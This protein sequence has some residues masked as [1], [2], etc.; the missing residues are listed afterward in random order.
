MAVSWRLALAACAALLSAS[1]AAAVEQPATKL[2]SAPLVTP[3]AAWTYYGAGTTHTEGLAAWKENG[4]PVN[5]PEIR[6]QA[7]SLGAERLAASQITAAEYAQAVFDYVYNN[8]GVEHRFG[9]GKGGRGALIEKYGTAFDQAELM[10]KLLREGGV[11]ANYKVGTITLAPGQFGKWTG[12]VKNLN[13]SAQSFDV[14]AR[15]ACQFLADGGIPARISTAGVTDATSCTALSG[16]LT[17]VTLGHIWVEAAGKLYDPA[18]KQYYIKAGVDL[19]AAMGCGTVSASTCGSSATAA[20]MTG[21]IQGSVSGAPTIKNL[22]E[23]AL[24]NQLQAY[25]ANLQ[26]YIQTNHHE[27]KLEDLTGGITA[28]PSSAPA[29]SAV[30]PYP[31]TIQYTW[32]GAIPDKFRTKFKLY[33][34]ADPG[35]YIPESSYELYVDEMSGRRIHYS[36]DPYITMLS[37][38]T[39]FTEENW[40]WGAI[41]PDGLKHFSIDHP[42]SA[43]AGTYAD[44]TVNLAIGFGIYAISAGV[45]TST[46]ALEQHYGGLEKGETKDS[47]A[48]AIHAKWRAQQGQSQKIIEAV[49]ATRIT[50]HHA[51]GFGG[52]DNSLA[53]SMSVTSATGIQTAVTSAFAALSSMSALLEASTLE[54]VSNAWPLYSTAFVFRTENARGNEFIHVTGTN[55]NSSV[56]AALSYAASYITPHLAAGR[57]I[58]LPTASPLNERIQIIGGGYLYEGSSLLAFNSAAEAHLVGAYNKGGSVVPGTGDPMAA[59]DKAPES[60]R[61]R[62][63]ASFDLADG[64]LTLMP[65]PD[66]VT[67]GGDG[68]ARLALVRH[69]AS[70]GTFD[71]RT[72]SGSWPASYGGADASVFPR[73]G[74]GWMHNFQ[75]SA[76]LGNDGLLAMGSE[77]AL[78]ASVSLAA[79]VTLKDQ[80]QTGDFPSRLSALLVGHWLGTKFLDNLVSVNLPPDTN[81]FGKLPDGTFVGSIGEKGSVAVTGSRSA[82]TA[83]KIEYDPQIPDSSEQYIKALGF[84]YGG[85]ALSYTRPDGD[86][87]TFTPGR[88][89]TGSSATIND[90]TFFPTTWL[91][92]NGLRLTFSYSTSIA[93]PQNPAEIHYSKGAKHLTQVSNNLGRSLSFTIADNKLQRVTDE[94]GRYVSYSL[95]CATGGWLS[96]DAFSVTAP[97]GGVTRYEYAP[98]SNSPNPATRLRSMYQLRRWFTP[99]DQ[100]TPFLWLKYDR[101]MR[102]GEVTDVLSS[103]SRYY[104]SG[105]GR[106]AWKRGQAIDPLGAV[107]TTTFNEH[108]KPTNTVDA[109]GRATSFTYDNAGRLIRTTYPELNAEERTYDARSNILT[110]TKK[111]KPGSGLA[112]ITM[113]NAY[114]EGPA[115]RICAN[116]K[117]CNKLASETDGRG[118]VA[119]YSWNTTYGDLT[120][121]MLPADS[122]GVRPQTDYAYALFGAAGSQFRLLTSKTEKISPSG[123]LATTYAYNTSNKYVLQTATV[124]PTGLVLATGFT[125]DSRGDPTAVDGPRTDVVDVTN[126]TWD[127]NRRLV[128]K[129][130][131]DP[132]GAGVLPRPAAK[133][134]YNLD[135]QPITL[136]KGTTTTATG[137]NFAIVE[138]SSVVYDAV[139][140]KVKQTLFDGV[141]TTPLAVTQFSYDAA[142]RPVCT[143]VRMNPAVFSSL[144]T[145]ACA[146]GTVGANGAD[147]ITKLEHDFAGQKTR[148]IRAYSTGRQQDYATYDYADNGKLEWVRDANSNQS[149]F[150]YDGHDR[151]LKLRFPDPNPALI[152]SS[153]TDYEQYGYDANGNRTTLR[154]RSGEVI[155]FTYDNLN[156]E[157]LK[158]IPGGTAA[159]VY[160]SYDLLGRKLYAR[161][162]SAVGQGVDFVWDK[163]GR[164]TSETDTA[165]SR[166][167]AYQHDK[168]GNRT[169]VT[170][171]DG[172]YAGYVYDAMSRVTAVNENGAIS[173]AGLLA[174]FG[175]DGLGR[176]TSIARGNGTTSS[177]GYDN[178]D[179]LT[180]LAQ[181][182]ASTANDV[183]LG[184]S[185]SPASQVL[186]RTVSN[187]NYDWTNYP[188][189]I[190]NYAFDGLNRDAA[191]A[192]VNGGYDA[193]GNLTY[194]GTR[195]FTYDLENRL[196]TVS[197]ATPTTLTYDPSGRLR[198]VTAGAAASGML[199]DGDRLSGEYNGATLLRRYVHGPGVDAPLVWYEGSGTTDRR[200]L[201]ADNQGSIIAWSNG[202]GAAGERYAYGPYGE[203]QAWAGSRFRYTG[204]IVL[205][206]AQLYHYKARAYD[207]KRGWFMQTDPIGYEA[208]NNLYRYARND[209]LNMIDP[210]GRNPAAGAVLGCAVAGPACPAGAMVGAAV[211]G[212]IVVGS[213]AC[214]AWC[215]DAAKAIGD[216]LR[217]DSQEVQG[218]PDGVVGEGP[219]SGG[220][221]TNSGPLAGE[222]G[223]TGDPQSDFDHLTG[224]RSKPAP[225]GSTLPP[226]SQVGDNGIVIRPGTDAR[227]PRIDIPASGDKPRETLHYPPPPPPP[228]PPDR[229]TG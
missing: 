118:N 179:R 127:A 227:G 222:H 95:D 140:R 48:N 9:L 170:W 11:T 160:S 27:A 148:E 78:H 135:G 137:S 93:I 216:I 124:D 91:Y 34:P 6:A 223:G 25:A 70:T 193:R 168:A 3:T 86:V 94:T 42:Y 19:S 60:L 176:R 17:S 41:Y 144:P 103:T 218:L 155:A 167:L 96:C 161:Y 158:D 154:K 196:L 199:Y 18:F 72:P 169:R 166:A 47:G 141:S 202:S 82:P 53:T 210:D 43:G 8:V 172:F 191:V 143:A 32:T 81:V 184:W 7:R 123:S 30:L 87:I 187:D 229:P 220:G 224:G 16:N 121:V 131:A 129:I 219:K 208:D 186:T 88:W 98:D 80:L 15:A 66:I 192:A 180:S 117:V 128:F 136:E 51:L 99:T 24:N 33:Q 35:Y 151:L 52:N 205:P 173:G 13:Q 221:R 164:L 40:G 178:A 215:D 107:T 69:Y 20:A 54:Q 213:A 119:N 104:A 159:D 139:G 105:I 56:Q 157:T 36:S 228:P 165:S 4:S 90:P 201:H 182:L 50:P 125:F 64:T 217:N 75:I 212:A 190:A 49:T 147:R 209:P 181:D 102:I 225:D 100:A 203:P 22:N 171:P 198:T 5:A 162:A 145:N 76:T 211:G 59:L 71:E 146:P 175:Y 108:N 116:Q 31:S 110:V 174:S 89:T 153:A 46:A 130:E 29:P 112:D 114:V 188:A 177:F 37:W 77:R 83:L 97:D 195:T 183:T 39:D 21:S 204:Q 14:D 206:E 113:S 2:I 101:L 74:G 152:A 26:T 57:S 111:A 150:E 149:T 134:V 189:A 197:G 67:G 109:L 1:T 62:S 63:A 138:R 194:D 85:V 79:L 12:V 214:L 61:T 55:Y 44:E 10:I 226:G 65:E 23:T 163:A 185:Y 200:W 92:A 142:D 38:D 84:N 120:Q 122:A 115:V 207:P 126:Y 133:T 132:D 68:P 106:E 58:I 45:G 156:R 73:M 28:N